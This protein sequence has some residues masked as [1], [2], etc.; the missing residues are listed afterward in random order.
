M[1]YAAI[2][3][4]LAVLTSPLPDR[5]A[6]AQGLG[7]LTIAPTRVVFEGRTR[8]EVLTLINNGSESAVYRIS[9]IEMRMLE[10]GGFER[11]KDGADPASVRSA[12][13][14]FRYAPRRIELQAGQTQSIR[15]LLRKPPELPE[16][17][18]R[19]HL[20]IQAIPKEGAGRS[21][22]SLGGGQDL[23]IKLTIIPGV[24]LP[25]IVRHGNL[26]ATPMLSDFSLTPADEGKSGPEL[27]F[28]INRSGTKS[29]YG[30]L[31]ATYF[32]S[33]RNNGVVVSQIRL[34]AVYVPNASRSVVM[35]LTLPED[36]EL[37]GGK[38]AVKFT[39]PPSEGAVEMASGE[40]P[41]P[42]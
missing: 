7:N 27:S 37:A 12:K 10:D 4:L 9:V 1:R 18:Y 21:V 8:S 39:T 15:I 14:M 32:P 33:G 16:G 24:T 6:A 13:G 41:V 11:V 40:I 23:S 36:V 38:I 42:Q 26:S 25:V 20:F 29:V 5:P 22:E 28:R 35:Q 17:E 31:T 30:D 19:S 2:L 3:V 34:L